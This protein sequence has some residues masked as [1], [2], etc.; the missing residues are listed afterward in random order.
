MLRS[1]PYPVEFCQGSPVLRP[2]DRLIVRMIV[3][4]T[5]MTEYSHVIRPDYSVSRLS[6][7]LD[8]ALPMK[9]ITLLLLFAAAAVAQYDIQCT[10][11]LRDLIPVLICMP[12]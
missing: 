5:L 12:R 4:C 6:L 8:S 3:F 10:F 11:N 7:Q 1:C 2:L 9:S